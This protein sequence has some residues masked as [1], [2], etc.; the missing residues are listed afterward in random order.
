MQNG[1]AVGGLERIAVRFLLRQ[2][3]RSLIQLRIRFQFRIGRG[4]SEFAGRLHRQLKLRC[5]LMKIGALLQQ[6]LREIVR[7]IGQ[8]L[9]RVDPLLVFQFFLFVGQRQPDKLYFPFLF[10]LQFGLVRFVIF[11]DVVIADFDVFDRSVGFNRTTL[12]NFCRKAVR[13]W[14]CFAFRKRNAGG[15]SP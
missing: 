11:F 2:L 4:A 13:N 12:T 1:K 3:E 7:A 8:F 6:R 15:Q 5:D 10:G 14:I 9:E